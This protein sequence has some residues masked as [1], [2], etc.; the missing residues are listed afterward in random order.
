SYLRRHTGLRTAEELGL[1]RKPSRAEGDGLRE[2]FAGRIVVPELRGGNCIWFIGRDLDVV[3]SR[4]KYLA[5]GG[6]RPVLGLERAA[7]QREA[8]VC[9]GIFDYLTAVGWKLPAWSP[10]GTS[11]P[12]DRVGFLARARVVY[13]AFDGDDAGRRS[14]AT[15]AETFGERWRTLDL[16]EGRDLNDL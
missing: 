11:L 16:P 4:P 5:L 9:E 1:L 3:P 12:A 14:D 2:F 8:F 7:G 6:E 10:C 13:G 15:W